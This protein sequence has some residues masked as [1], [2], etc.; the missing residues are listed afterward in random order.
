MEEFESLGV[1]FYEGYNIN[2]PLIKKI[3]KY[4]NTIIEE[5]K[6]LRNYEEQAKIKNSF[7][8]N[9]N[10][11]F[12]FQIKDYLVILQEMLEINDYILIIS[13]IY[14]DRLF[15]E[16]SIILTN[17]NIHK[18]LFTSILISA[19]NNEDIYNNNS[20]YSSEINIS[21]KEMNKLEFSFLVLVNFNLYISKKEFE[22]YNNYINNIKI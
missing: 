13:L 17:E 4:L 22:K 14:L 9:N 16:S 11:L 15:E 12:E 5:N 3:N 18:L 10:N 7:I 21:L 20:I 6:Y 19:K 1:K 8:F 2:L